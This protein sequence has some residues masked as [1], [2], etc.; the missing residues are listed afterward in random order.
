M[1]S[2]YRNATTFATAEEPIRQTIRTGAIE[3]VVLHP[4]DA[5]ERLRNLVE[6]A[7]G[8]LVTSELRGG[9][10]AQ[11]ASLTVRI[12]EARFEQL[13]T[14]IERVG[15]RVEGEHFEA[16]DVTKQYVD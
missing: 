9:E 13:R 2:Q 4:T 10:S 15:L 3:L 5:A 11:N 8:Y 12:P 6:A 1:M 16:Q 14:E 7:G